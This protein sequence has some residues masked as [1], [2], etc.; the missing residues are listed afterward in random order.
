M[1]AV[2]VTPD[3]DLEVRDAPEPAAP[4]PGHVLVEMTACAIN[5]GD[6][7]FLK[8]RSLL[9]MRSS[10]HDIWGASGAGCVTAIGEGVPAHYLG[11]QVAIYRSI[12]MI[13]STQTAGLWSDKAQVHH[14]GCLILPDH[15][16]ARDYSGSLVNIITAYAF[17]RQIVEEGHRGIIATAGNAATGRGLLELARREGVPVL[18]IVRSAAAQRELAEL[19]AEHVLD[20][21][22]P[23]FESRFSDLAG[24]LQATAVFDGVGGG[25]VTR[26]APLLPM[27]AT[28][29]SYGFMAGP[30]PVSFPTTL[31][32][33]K[34][35]TLR[36]FSNF[37]SATVQDP[38]RLAAALTAL[39]EGIDHPA[40]RT[41]IGQ[42]FGF[43]QIAAAMSANSEGKSILM[44]HLAV[45]D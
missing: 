9:N 40:F 31:L 21:S 26:I 45:R 41:R 5:H 37:G 29:Y 12:S 22:A 17:L 19:G 3:R 15:V 6:H 20:A 8:M 4:P 18:A 27:N 16:D 24:Q 2:C 25:L 42:S 11:R 35:L 1:K 33:A 38:K 44:P 32:I 7:T 39:S 36:P 13:H 14:L 28:L 30:E 43:D 10:L 23:D 34:N